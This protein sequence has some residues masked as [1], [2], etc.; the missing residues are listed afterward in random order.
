MEASWW[1]RLRGKLGLVLMGGAM[2]SKS[3]IQFSAEGWDCVP[4]CYLTWGQ[5]IV[6]VKIMVISFKKSHASTATLRAPTLQQATT[7]PCLCQR[8]LDTSGK[9]G[10][11]SYGVTALFS[12]ILMHT[13]FCLCP[14]RVYFPVLCKFWQ[15]YGGVNGDLLQEGLCQTQVL[16][17]QSPC[18]CSSPLLTCTSTGDTQTQFCLRFQDNIYL[19]NESP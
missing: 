2:L 4:P 7:D 18:P 11:V 1:D 9:T 17:R 16:C 10:S 3:L 14:P 19:L 6:E 8:L 5:T 12:W 13:T 15:L